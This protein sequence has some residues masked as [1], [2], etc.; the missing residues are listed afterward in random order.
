MTDTGMVD[1]S[2]YDGETIYVAIRYVSDG[3]GS[4]EGAND[5]IQYVAV[6]GEGAALGW[7]NTN[8]YGWVYFYTPDV[9]LSLDLGVIYTGT[10]PWIYQSLYGYLYVV[11]RVPGVAMWLYDPE[12]GYLYLAEG[13]GGWFSA[14]N[15]DWAYENFFGLHED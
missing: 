4:G 1:I 8:E 6:G 12:L 3:T 13:Q 9:G 7:Q 5:Y 14:Q 15:L 10:Y 11:V 2:A